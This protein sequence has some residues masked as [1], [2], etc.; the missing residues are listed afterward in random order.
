MLLLDAVTLFDDLVFSA[1]TTTT[2][3]F[4]KVIV[5]SDPLQVSANIMTLSRT[6]L[7]TAK[8]RAGPRDAT[9]ASH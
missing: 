8:L 5:M 1:E 4:E 3:N 6:I 7:L 2:T 9:I